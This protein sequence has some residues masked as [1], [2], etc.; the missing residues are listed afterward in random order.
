MKL[1]INFLSKL[2]VD[3]VS[4]IIG[5]VTLPVITRALGPEGYGLYSYLIVILS[6]FGFFLDFGYLNYGTNKLCEK[7]DSRIVI[8]KIISLQ[9]LTVMFSYLVLIIAGYLIFDFNKYILL[10]I[11]SFSFIAQIFS[12]RYY[13]LACNKLY[14]NSI[15]ELAGQLVYVGAIFFIFIKFPSVLTLIILSVIQ[16]V[17]TSYFY[18]SLI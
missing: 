2:G 10:L 15:S 14:Y 7:I 18:S 9:L 8:G 4:R 3:S 17:V 1:I 6:Y 13:Y 5:F 12:I 16:T 11:F